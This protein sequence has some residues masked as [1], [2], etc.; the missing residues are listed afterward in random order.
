[1]VNLSALL[2]LVI[3]DYNLSSSVVISDVFESWV[4]A[5]SMDMTRHNVVTLGVS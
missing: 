1:M 2:V 5:V 3:F 4:V